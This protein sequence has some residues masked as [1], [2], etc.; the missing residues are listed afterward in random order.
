[1]QAFYCHPVKDIDYAIG[2]VSIDNDM[3]AKLSHDYYC[4]NS[5][6]LLSC[7]QFV[8]QKL[9]TCSFPL[10]AMPVL[11]LYEYAAYNLAHNIH[12]TVFAQS[13]KVLSL[14]QLSL[15]NKAVKLLQ[16]LMSGKSLPYVSSEHYQSNAVVFDECMP[17]NHPGNIKIL[18]SITETNLSNSLREKYGVFCYVELMLVKCQLLIQIASIC[19]EVP[20][21]THQLRTL[22]SADMCCSE[23]K[24]ILLEKSQYRLLRLLKEIDEKITGKLK[25]CYLKIIK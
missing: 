13:Y 21:A 9:V 7:L 20:L 25:S 11:F 10:Q 16:E 8:S 14:T 24:A 12:H 22:L 6:L 17:L 1:M 23:I 15:L 4:C 19:E 5:S 2:S 3:A 18:S